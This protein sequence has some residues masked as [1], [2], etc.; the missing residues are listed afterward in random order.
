MSRSCPHCG[1]DVPDRALACPEC[2]SDAE[3]GWADVETQHDAAF[4]EFTEEDYENVLRDLPGA[5]PPAR[6]GR[7]VALI[8]VAAIALLAFLVAFVL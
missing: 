5:P 8:V 7:E 6:S 1:A 2:G 4:G 3:T